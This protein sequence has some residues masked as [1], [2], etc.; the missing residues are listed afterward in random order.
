MIKGTSNISVLKSALWFIMAACIVLELILF[1]S[2]SNLFGSAVTLLSTWMFF[3]WVLKIDIIRKRPI[4]FIAFLQLFFFMYLPLPVT[5]LDGNEMSHDLFNPIETYL[6]QL[7]YFAICILAFSLAGRKLNKN[8]V[9]QWLKKMG[10]FVQ[11]TNSWLWILG[12]IGLAFRLFMMNQQGQGDTEMTA[13][14][15]LNMFSELIYA[16]I[17]LLFGPLMGMKECSKK[18]RYIVYSYIAFLVVLLIA[19]NSRSK[20]LSPLVVYAFCYLLQQI[21]T[22]RSTLWLSYKKMVILLVAVLTISGPAADMAIAMV[23]VRGQRT[24]MSFTELLSESIETFQDKERLNTYRRLAAA[25]DQAAVGAEWQ[26]SYVS[27]PFL[28]RLCNYRVV[29]ATI[30]HAHKAGFANSEMLDFFADKVATMFPGPISTFLFPEIDKSDLSFSAMDKLYNITTKNIVG[31][32]KVGGDVG[33]GLATFGLFYFPLCLFVY[34]IV[35]YILDGICIVING[36]MAISVFTLIVIY[37]S[38]FLKFQVAG[39]VI[40]QTA[41]ILWGFW[42]TT[43]W[44]CI[45]Y[46]LIRTIRGG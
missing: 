35:F 44:H 27:S 26:E 22:Y 45:V 4:S 28:D 13:A 29:D 16:P 34:F 7:L 21:Y 25:D 38:Y 31:G 19:T 12:G 11:P 17:C 15:T 10:Y 43:I 5:L 3:T 14:G 33:L 37:F 9:R 42:W 24:S 20:M 23:V 32:F 46:K 39:G 8:K 18:T 30:Y 40:S 6:L 36:K 41:F 2:M 1:P